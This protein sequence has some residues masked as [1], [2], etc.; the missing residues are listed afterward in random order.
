MASTSLITASNIFKTKFGKLSRTHYNVAHPLSSQVK[1]TYNFVGS[2]LE[3]PVE[4]TLK[5][6]TGGGPNP[7]KSA[8]SN[9]EMLTATRK[10]VVTRASIKDE[11]IV[12]SKTDEAAFIAAMKWEVKKTIESQDRS[13]EML[14][15]GTGDGAL[16]TI[17]SGTFAADVINAVISAATF[18]SA[19]FEVNDLVNLGAG[20]SIFRV[21]NVVD[22]TRT[23]TMELFEGTSPAGSQ[24]G[25][26][27]YLQGMRNAAP[28]GLR[29]AV[30]PQS[31][32]LYGIT[33]KRRWKGNVVDAANEAISMDLLNTAILNTHREV[34]KSPNLVLASYERFKDILTLS[35]D[36][37]VYDVLKSRENPEVKLSFKSIQIMT[38]NG[39]VDVVLDRF[40]KASEVFLVNTDYIEVAHAPEYGWFDRDDSIFLREPNSYDYEAKYGGY[41]ECIIHPPFQAAIINLGNLP[42]V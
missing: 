37:K 12:T 29:G 35:E 11:A 17:E 18:V 16:G 15:H 6:S 3:Y 31:G 13:L 4:T 2:K 14:F 23:V 5:G 40:L 42:A 39:A 33:I 27:I 34:G 20:T 21:S 38:P 41:L 1:K 28:M 19:N 25:V 8:V 24:A 9:P 26:V 10:T 32:T 7:P 36:Q 30:L 22:S